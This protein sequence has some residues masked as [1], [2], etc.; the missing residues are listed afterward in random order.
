[1]SNHDD[2]LVL[3]TREKDWWWSMQEIFPSIERVWADIGR[4]QPENV[5]TLCVPVLPEIQQEVEAAAAR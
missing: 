3:T 1:M 4:F 2:V 5:R